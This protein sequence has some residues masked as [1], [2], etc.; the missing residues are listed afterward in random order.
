MHSSLLKYGH[1][2]C[3]PNPFPTNAFP[4]IRS[5]GLFFSSRS[6]LRPHTLIHTHTHTHLLSL[7]VES[8]WSWDEGNRANC[9]SINLLVR[10]RTAVQSSDVWPPLRVQ[11]NVASTVFVC[12]HACA[13]V[14][15]SDRWCIN[16]SS[17][18]IGN[19][20]TALIMIIRIMSLSHLHALQKPPLIF[21]FPRNL[22]T[23]IAERPNCHD[24]SSPPTTSYINHFLLV[25][26]CG[27]V[28]PCCIFPRSH[29]IFS[30]SISRPD[31]W[32]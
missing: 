26:S 22:D 29:L 19:P 24:S 17:E 16:L 10:Q 3:V 6:L 28:A 18:T 20:T 27:H 9:I 8:E 15:V 14:C 1:F 13:C 25:T 5:G 31:D 12:L 32:M 7:P 2:D 23:V 4:L 21:P 30:R 11:K